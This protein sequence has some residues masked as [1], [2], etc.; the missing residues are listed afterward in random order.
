MSGFQ[1]KQRGK[2]GGLGKPFQSE[3]HWGQRVEKARCTLIEGGV[4]WGRTANTRILGNF[5]GLWTQEEISSS[6]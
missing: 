1:E 3:S 6:F 4:D 5:K 2:V